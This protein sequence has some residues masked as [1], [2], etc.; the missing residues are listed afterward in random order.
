MK[1]FKEVLLGIAFVVA[2]ITLSGIATAI[3]DVPH[4]ESIVPQVQRV[5]SLMPKVQKD[6]N[7]YGA[8][9]WYEPLEIMGGSIPEEYLLQD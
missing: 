4:R 6:G 7:V 9:M 1:K 5:I 2:I 8:M 3:E